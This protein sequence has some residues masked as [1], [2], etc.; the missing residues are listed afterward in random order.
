[1][2]EWGSAVPVDLFQGGHG[3][4]IL[5]RKPCYITR[6]FR[7]RDK[8]R[9][10]LGTHPTSS[11]VFTETWFPRRI[12]K[13]FGAS[14]RSLGLNPWLEQGGIGEVYREKGTKMD[15][16]KHSP[17]RNQSGHLQVITGGFLISHYGN[18]R[19][20]ESG[21]KSSLLPKINSIERLY[22]EILS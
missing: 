16:D 12:L 11:I 2:S 8:L 9:H 19:S 15:Q 7:M 14:S 18:G 4:E 3:T 10:L 22:S 20:P 21:S 5:H 13:I 6:K 1:M 17:V